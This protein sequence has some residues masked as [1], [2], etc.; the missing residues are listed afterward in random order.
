MTHVVD[1]VTVP[2]TVAAVVCFSVG[3]DDLPRIGEKLGQ[4]FG[5]VMTQLQMAGLAPAGPALAHYRP[6]DDGFEVSAGFRVTPASALPAGLQRLDLGN[7][8]AAHTTHIGSYATL[9][10]AYAELMA[11][12][13]HDGWRLGTGAPMWEEYWSEPGTPPSET[14]TEIYWPVTSTG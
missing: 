10:T 7:L 12:A 9:P 6:I 8:V 11:R 3:A 2:V 14:R 13:E 1:I 5:T 4:A